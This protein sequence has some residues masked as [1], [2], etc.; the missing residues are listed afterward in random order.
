M[1]TINDLCRTRNRYVRLVSWKG[2]NRPRGY[3]SGMDRYNGM[4]V[5]FAPLTS[6]CTCIDVDGW[7]FMPRHVVEILKY[8]NLQDDVFDLDD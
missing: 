4:V 7:K 5:Y 3:V 1:V 6:S 8:N 2:N